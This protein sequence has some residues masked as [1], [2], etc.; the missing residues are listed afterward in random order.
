MHL[1]NTDETLRA[2]GR[3][4]A[5]LIVWRIWGVNK[6]SSP[7]VTRANGRV[8]GVPTPRTKL[9]QV[10][11]IIIESGLIYTTLVVATFICELAKSNAIYGVSDVVRRVFP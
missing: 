4:T 5:G 3:A 8:R 1:L 2:D 10:I 11:R 7:V 9:E 6:R